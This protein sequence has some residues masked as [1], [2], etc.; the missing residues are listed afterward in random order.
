MNAQQ[1]AAPLAVSNGVIPCLSVSDAHAA[2][3][4]YEGSSG[5]R[6]GNFY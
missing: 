5:I 3:A 6:V 1:Q 4:F 2:A